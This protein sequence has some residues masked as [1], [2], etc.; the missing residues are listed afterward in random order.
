MRTVE[1]PWLR[2]QLEARG[3]NVKA[4][5]YL[6]GLPPVGPSWITEHVN[7][8]RHRPV[9]ERALARY[10]RISVRRLR[11]CLWPAFSPP[12]RVRTRARV[13]NKQESK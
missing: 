12:P 3:I 13:V 8:R 10:F 9:V 5:A 4:L 11:H 6:A 7:R 1:N 2:R